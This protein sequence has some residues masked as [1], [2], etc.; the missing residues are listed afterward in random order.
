MIVVLVPESGG[1]IQAMK[2]GLMEIADIFVVNKADPPGADRL[3]KDLRQGLHLRAATAIESAPPHHGLDLARI[4]RKESCEEP[5]GPGWSPPVLSTVAQS[6]EGVED[7]IDTIKA[8][9]FWLEESGEL[10]S[11]GEVAGKSASKMLWIVNYA[12]RHGVLIQCLLNW[13][14]VWSEFKRGKTPPTRLLGISWTDSY[15]DPS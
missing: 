3:V 11:G 9:R 4:M 14:K 1:A 5:R 12:E 13:T 2:T 15:V 8:H 7:L 10:E 6:G